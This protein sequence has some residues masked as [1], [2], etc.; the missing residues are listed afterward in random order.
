MKVKTSIKRL[1]ELDDRIYHLKGSG[2]VTEADLSEIKGDKR[3]VTDFREGMSHMMTVEG[4]SKYADMPVQR[5]LQA[6]GEI[7]EPVVILS[8][9]V[10]ACED[11]QWTEGW[12][13]ETFLLPHQ[14]EDLS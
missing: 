11:P 12:L 1:I 6:S 3:L 10:S 2:L 5:K 13:A 9:R 4:P 14:K 8:S 7:G